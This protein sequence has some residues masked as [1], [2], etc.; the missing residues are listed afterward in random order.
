MHLRGD[1]FYAD[2]QIALDAR[3]NPARALA[4]RHSWRNSLHRERETHIPESAP[5]TVVGGPVQQVRDPHRQ[6]W[7]E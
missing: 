7:V 6:C 5:N 3:H 1:R 4:I 2:R